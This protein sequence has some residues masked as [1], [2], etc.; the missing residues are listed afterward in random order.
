MDKKNSKYVFEHPE[1]WKD[2]TRMN[3]LFA[4]FRDRE[5]N[6]IFYDVKMKFWKDL[7]KE[8]CSNTG[9]F[10]VQDLSA[11]FTRNRRIPYCTSNVVKDLIM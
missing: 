1:C 11:A 6:P 5:V 9:Y 3:A 10:T 7:I 4:P 2:E 8:A